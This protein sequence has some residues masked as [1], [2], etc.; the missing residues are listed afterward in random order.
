MI[1]QRRPRVRLE[2]ELYAELRQRVLQRDAWRCQRC[3]S[4]RNLEVH[5]VRFRSS[6]GDDSEENL[7]TLCG[8]CHRC[9]HGGLSVI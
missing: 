7:I 3:G 5:H 4:L 1:R 8:S 9:H 2:R 6:L